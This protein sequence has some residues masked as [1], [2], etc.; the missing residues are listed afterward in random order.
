MKKLTVTTFATWES[1]LN[2]F[3]AFTTPLILRIVVK[4]NTSASATIS[5]ICISTKTF[6]LFSNDVLASHT[7]YKVGA[8]NKFEFEFDIRHIERNYNANKTFTVKITD[9]LGFTYESERLTINRLKTI[10]AF[11]TQ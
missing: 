6:F 4:N 3:G 5:R 2:I 9:G 8:N 11:Y 1:G 10:K 7:A